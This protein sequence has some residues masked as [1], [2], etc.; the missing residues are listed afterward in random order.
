MADVA[1]GTVRAPFVDQAK[2]LYR[3]PPPPP[4]SKKHKTERKDLKLGNQDR[5]VAPV[6]Y[7]PVFMLKSL[8]YSSR[9]LDG[10]FL[11]L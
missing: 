5:N 11:S 8:N 3:N 1:A 9:R 6:T 7:R 10:T 2:S 4:S